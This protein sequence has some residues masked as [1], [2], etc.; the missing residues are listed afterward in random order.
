MGA[1]T[2]IRFR[3]GTVLPYETLPVPPVESCPC[4]L[5]SITQ[6]PRRGRQTTPPPDPYRRRCLP[7]RTVSGPVS[8]T[9]EEAKR[10]AK[11]A[12]R[13]VLLWCVCWM[14]ITS[15]SRR[16]PAPRL[17]RAISKQTTNRRLV[18]VRCSSFMTCVCV[19]FHVFRAKNARN[20]AILLCNHYVAI[21]KLITNRRLCVCFLHRGPIFGYFWPLFGLF[22]ASFGLHWRSMAD[23]GLCDGRT[24]GRWDLGIR[25]RHCSALLTPTP[26]LGRLP[27]TGGSLLLSW[28]CL[29]VG[30]FARGAF[31]VAGY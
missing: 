17:P 23:R 11:L 15:P 2:P 28:A 14:Q 8:T 25:P 13:T 29:P 30:C 24:K 12:R 7:H 6:R 27:H 31:R 3:T 9:I 16:E 21:G 20:P 22:L 26:T 5:D 19:N 18:C 1:L 10:A 4:K